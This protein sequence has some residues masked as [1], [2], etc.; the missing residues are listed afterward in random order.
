MKGRDDG[1]RLAAICLAIGMAALICVGCR[2]GKK[3]LQQFDAQ[4]LDYF[5]TVTSITIY[6]EN[7][8][9]FEKYRAAV[10]EDMEHY[11]K[12]F[13]IYNNYDGINNVKS[14]NDNAGLLPVTVELELYELLE[15]SIEQYGKTGGKVNIAMGSVLS[16][17]HK[18]REEGLAYPD[19]AAVP[20]MIELKRANE[21][22]DI[23]KIRMDKE[24]SQVYL[25]DKHMSL[26]VGAVAK[27]YATHKIAERLRS[28]GVVSALL[29]VGGNVE[30]IGQRGDGRPW[31][32][33]IQNPDTSSPQSYLHVMELI[34]Q[35]LVTSGVY[36]RFYEVDGVRYHHIIQPDELMPWDK[37]LSVTILARDGGLADAYSTA[38]FNMEIDEGEDF[39]ESIDGI[40]AMWILGDGTEVYSSGFKEFMSE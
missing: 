35:A 9:E 12:L 11:H 16:L 37:Y 7:E 36:Q 13:D 2:S 17:W 5:D 30:T 27:G 25:P 34:D 33:G 29:S 28:M 31:R 38:V 1:L 39:I 26:D 40:E 8:E 15:F 32:V 21:Y 20:D 18:Y 24:K 10:E 6:A 23:Y 14:I 3:S 4:Y 22:T 19:D